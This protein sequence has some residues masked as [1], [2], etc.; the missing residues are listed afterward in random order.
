MTINQFHVTL[1]EVV[2]WVWRNADVTVCNARMAFGGYK[3]EPVG[4]N[5]LLLLCTMVVFMSFD[6]VV[7]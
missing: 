6:H 3:I 4:T 1:V 5:S 2:T 7:D